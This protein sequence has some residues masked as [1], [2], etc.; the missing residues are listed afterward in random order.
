MSEH[1]PR[2]AGLSPSPLLLALLII[3]ATIVVVGVIAL[4]LTGTS[5]PAPTQTG[6]M[7]GASAPQSEPSGK[8]AAEI[9][10]T[11]TAL[12][13]TNVPV[14]TAIPTIALPTLIPEPTP[15]IPGPTAQFTTQIPIDQWLV[16]D[17][18]QAG[19]SIKYPPDW[20]L[21]TTAPED[22]VF[23][24]TTQLFSYDPNDPIL[25]S[26]SRPPLPNFTKIEITVVDNLEATGEV[27]LPDQTIE[28][29][30]RTSRVID[31]SVGDQLKLID[32]G[33][34]IVGGVPAYYQLIQYAT[35]G[36]AKTTYVYHKGKLIFIV[37]GFEEADSFND[38]T[39]R[40]MMETI[41]FK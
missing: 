13:P 8:P 39:L 12:I 31:D 28:N 36:L 17:D 40:G 27:F 33:A 2:K 4:L 26:K 3:A 34:T 11:P 16:Y 10:D 9:L 14:H 38:L 41:I 18:A 30:V 25:E 32:E 6:A 5:A 24:S 29:W 15:Y 21:R 19:F 37:H 1:K 35:R 20:Y 22:R 7:A 23:G